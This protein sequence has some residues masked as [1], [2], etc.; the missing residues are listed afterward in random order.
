[1]ELQ[2]F[3]RTTLASSIT[4]TDTTIPLNTAPTKTKG[5]LVIDPSN[6]SKRE[7]IYYT[8]VSGNNVICP[9][10]ATGRGVGGTTAQSHSSGAEVIMAFVA[11]HYDNIYKEFAPNTDFQDDDGSNSTVSYQKIARG[12]FSLTSSNVVDDADSYGLAE[13]TITLPFSYKDTNYGVFLTVTA[14]GSTGE[15]QDFNLFAVIVSSNTFK[16]RVTWETSRWWGE[17][18]G[19]WMT[20]GEV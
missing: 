5:Y 9:D 11:E 14:I 13:K 3:F 4:A 10:A 12:K 2:N 19:N 8:S 17:I 18:K 6:S 20:I 7:I 15:V 16:V 1:M